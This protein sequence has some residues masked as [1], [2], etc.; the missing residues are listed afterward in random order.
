M[1]LNQRKSLFP[2]KANKKLKELLSISTIIMI[3]TQKFLGIENIA[4]E[5]IV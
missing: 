2:L 5:K 4:A 3:N 1:M